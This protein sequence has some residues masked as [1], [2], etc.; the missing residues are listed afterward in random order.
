MT[1]SFRWKTLDFSFFIYSRWGFT[2]PAGRETLDGRYMKRDLDYWVEG[3]NENAE[4]YKPVYNMD[5]AYSWSMNYQNGSF[6]K[7]RNISLGW[8]IPENWLKGLKVG[9]SNVRIYA[10]VNNPFF[11]YKSCKWLDTDLMNYNNNTK[12]FG[13]DVSIRSYVIGLNVT[14]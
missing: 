9:L 6:I 2:V 14:F 3:V 5:D 13:S 7:V 12:A 11:I 1:N 10:Q 8:S 4:Y